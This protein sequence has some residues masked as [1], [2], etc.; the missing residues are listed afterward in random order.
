[1]NQKDKVK[2]WLKIAEND[3]IVTNHLFGYGDYTYALFFGH[4][5]LEKILKAIYVD[6]Q[7][8]T[9]PFS[10]NLVYLAEKCKMEVHVDKLELLEEISDY[11]LEARYP[12]EK[13]SFFK[14]CTIEFTKNKLKQINEVREWL[15]Q[16]LQF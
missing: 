7:N 8:D 14:K 6:K 3:W 12:D 4:M 2:Y 5:T 11:N 1:M 16:H 9:P 15:L 10:H 13:L